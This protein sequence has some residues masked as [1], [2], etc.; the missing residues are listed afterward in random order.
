MM[1]DNKSFMKVLKNTEAKIDVLQTIVE[2]D[3]I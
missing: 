1:L 2:R 3:D